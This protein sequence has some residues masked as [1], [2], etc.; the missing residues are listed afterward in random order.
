LG[1]T[2]K[3]G[4]KLG[5]PSNSELRRWLDKGSVLVNGEKPKAK[6]SVEF[7]IWQLVFFPTSKKH[8]TTLVWEQNYGT[9]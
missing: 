5:P 2:S 6:D 1:P 9:K 8:K 4:S 7:P 3:E